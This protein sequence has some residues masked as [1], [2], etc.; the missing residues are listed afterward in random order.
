SP[1]AEVCRTAGNRVPGPLQVYRECLLQALLDEIGEFEILEKHVEELFLRQCEL[2]GIFART[3]RA[4]LGTTTSFPAGWPGNF[5]AP[6]IL[7]VPRDDV[8]GP[9]RAA[10]VVKDRFGDPPRRDSHLLTMANICHLSLAQCLLHRRFYLGPGPPQ[11]ALSITEAFALRVRTTVDD[12]HGLS[13]GWRL[14]SPT[15]PFSPAYTTRPAA[16]LAVRYSPAPPCA[17]ENRRASFLSP[18]PSSCQS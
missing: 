10:A 6:Y 1:N 18:Y 13:P 5:V 11:E 2:E 4:S 14:Q 15:R 16:G 17:R 3:V 9:S 8:L 7:L 12:V